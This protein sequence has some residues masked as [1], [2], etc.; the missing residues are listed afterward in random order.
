MLDRLAR[1]TASPAGRERALALRPVSERPAVVLRQRAAAEAAWLHQGSVSL[2]L[3]GARDVRDA[4]GAAA[5]GLRLDPLVLREVAD[6][7]RC[8]AQVRRALARAR[9]GAPLLAAE[10]QALPDL[11]ALRRLIDGAVDA[12][13]AL[14]D[15]AS[16]ELSQIRAEISETHDALLARMQ[17]VVSSPALRPALSDAIVTQREGRYVVPVRSEARSALP[18]VVHDTSS[19]GRTVYVEPFAVVELGNR[20][21]ERQVQ[22][23]REIERILRELSSVVGES[24]ADLAES[25][26]RLAA[27]DC[28]VAAA[29][30]GRELGA[31]LPADAGAEQPW[32]HDAPGELRLLDA[33]HPLLVWE[34]GEV[35]PVSLAVGGGEGGLL[36]T[37]PNT[38]GKTVALKSAGLITLMA[39]CGLPVPAEPGSTI[40]V[41]DAVFADIG[42]EQSIEQSLSTFSSHVTAIID[43]IE[44]AGPRSLALLDELGAGTDPVEGAVLAVAIVERLVAAG[45]TLIATTHHGELKAHAHDHPRLLNAS[46][47][48][49]VETLSPTYRLRMGIPGESNAL[50]ISER[51]GMPADVVEAA[52]GR[53]SGEERELSR[54]LANLREQL[55]RAETRA[56]AAGHD[57]AEAERLRAELAASHEQLDAESE[58]RRAEAQRHLRDELRD[59]ERLLARTRRQ[60]E[61]ARLE[62]ADADMARAREAARAVRRPPPAPR[63][64][65]RELRGRLSVVPGARVWLA[66][67]SVPGE[68]LSAPDARGEFELT[69]GALRTRARLAQVVRTEA[70]AGG[71][72]P[73]VRLR[74]GP[75][76][77]P[78]ESI[79]V[80]GRTLDEALPAVEEYLD[81][82]VRV[83]RS[84]VLVIHGKG[85][86]TLRRAVRD[87]LAH[88]PLVASQEPA[89]RAEGGEGVTVAHLTAL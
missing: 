65:R 64:E 42:D 45:V 8:A 59:T 10:G 36:I 75:V 62:Q 9:D 38:G 3:A 68:A 57:R 70:P 46:V 21:R 80:R 58:R 69:L 86:G 53:V 60:V 19:S 52:R 2:A 54:M 44:R 33:R 22:E 47:E 28:A 1:L 29:A 78:G 66:G 81:R 87:L 41:Y 31:G 15:G 56:E 83:G 48:F 24:S 77:D 12:R 51:L 20:W 16:A 49:D 4:A 14:L 40:P 27:I 61:A 50:A 17:S 85:T 13:G 5:R 76:D 30:L 74:T 39:L 63:P 71:E 25:V 72:A 18:G 55:E 11:D 79:E 37:G 82:A 43:V 35:V 67:M 34:G 84:R 88:H 26:E 32:L 7:V 6:T 23:R 89:E 73:A